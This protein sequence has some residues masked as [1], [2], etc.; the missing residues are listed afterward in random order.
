MHNASHYMATV[1]IGPKGQIVIP[2]EIRDMFQLEVGENLIIMADTA[3]G[4]ALQ[5]QEI[6][7]NFAKSFFDGA[8]KNDPESGEAIF[9]AAV[10]KTVN[11]GRAEK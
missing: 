3:R 4:I 8:P 2:K 9:A 6:L 10:Q 7:E 5:K 1:K 11:E